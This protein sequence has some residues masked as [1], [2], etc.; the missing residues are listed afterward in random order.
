MDFV[1]GQLDIDMAARSGVA[2]PLSTKQ[3]F[4]KMYPRLEISYIRL[5]GLNP[6]IYM[7]LTEPIVNVCHQCQRP[8]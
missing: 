8:Y 3:Y 2:T 5:S 1:L 6:Q 4:R 7:D